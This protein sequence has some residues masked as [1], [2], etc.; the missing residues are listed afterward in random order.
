MFCYFYS[1]MATLSCLI[2]FFFGFTLSILTEESVKRETGL[3][4]TLSYYGRVH[5]YN[6][7]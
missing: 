3:M 4:Q 1:L 2:Q 5:H 6:I 7:A